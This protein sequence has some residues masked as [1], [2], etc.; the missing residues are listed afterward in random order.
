MMTVRNR[1]QTWSGF[2]LH[3]FWLF[4]AAFF[5]LL[6]QATPS[7]AA[8]MGSRRACSPGSCLAISTA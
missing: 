7:E 2:Q 1:V 6:L 3:V 5:G 8:A 4:I